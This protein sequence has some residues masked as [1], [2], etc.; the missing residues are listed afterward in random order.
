MIINNCIL[1]IA[2]VRIAA[3][4]ISEC[5]GKVAIRIL[6]IERNALLIE[7]DSILIIPKKNI[8]TLRFTFT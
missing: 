8:N 1:Q 7:L 5:K 4:M 3:N 2:S 6:R